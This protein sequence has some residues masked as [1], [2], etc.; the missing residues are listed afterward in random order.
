MKV[1][2]FRVFRLATVVLSVHFPSPYR[3][4]RAAGV[5]NERSER[6]AAVREERNEPPMNEAIKAK[7]E[8]ADLERGRRRGEVRRER[9][10]TDRTIRARG[11]NEQ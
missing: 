5:R 1:R 8:E 3:L 9:R 6:Q 10:S 4:V 7:R 11:W 2:E